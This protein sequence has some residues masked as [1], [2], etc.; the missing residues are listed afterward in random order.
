MVILYGGLKE[1]PEDLYEA[2]ALDGTGPVSRFRYVTWPLL[3]P[4]TGV[5]VVLGFVYTVK[6][7]DIILVLTGGG[8]ANG[9]PDPGRAVLQAVVPELRV[10][11]GRGD[12]EPADRGR[13]DLRRH[14]PAHQQAILRYRS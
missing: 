4:V 9:E 7:I 8:P 5:V 14:L 1:I 3:R 6:V 10:R 11:A 2:A 13:P 12:V